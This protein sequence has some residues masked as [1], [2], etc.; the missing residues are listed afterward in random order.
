[1]NIGSIVKIVPFA[2]RKAEEPFHKA[3]EIQ[4]EVGAKADLGQTFLG[5]GRLQQSEEKK[6][7]VYVVPELH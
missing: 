3:I 2:D 1:M 5:L 7:L 6:S 4:R